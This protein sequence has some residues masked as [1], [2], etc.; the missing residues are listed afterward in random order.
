MRPPLLLPLFGA[1]TLPLL[2]EAPV[3]P[4]V[5]GFAVT[6]SATLG[7]QYIFRGL[8]QTDGQP[9]VQA[10]LDLAHGAGWYVSLAGSNISWF[11]D[12]NANTAAHPVSLGSPGP[13]GAK[14]NSA[15]TE[16][17]VFGGYK[18]GFAKDWTLD[19]GLCRYL[20]PGTYGNLGAFRN[21]HTTEA[22]MGLTYS[23]ASLKVSRV[24]SA[25]AFGVSASQGTT[26][27]DLSLAIP[28][29]ES[30][31]TA[32]AHGGRT[33]YA[34]SGNTLLT[35]SDYKVG[36]AKEL[37]GYTFALAATNAG[38]KAR[39][40]DNDTPVYENALGRNIGK[41]RVTFTLTKSF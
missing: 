11:T 28:L 39:A 4:V 27:V 18:W 16:V 25:C 38:T 9:M 30:G 41:G 22:Y 8:T 6:G 15:G 37:R 1:L 36:L 14:S 35:Y 5:L 7:T 17:D 19:L 2:G 21:P 13:L 29:G 33:S 40:A 10:E 20:Y 34:G 31:W 23:W 32:L 24:I 26:Y 12:Q 3:P